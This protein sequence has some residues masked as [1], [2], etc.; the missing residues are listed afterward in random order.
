M[1]DGSELGDLALKEKPHKSQHFD[2]KAF[3]DASGSIL[4]QH[5]VGVCGI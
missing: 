5:R 3:E 4:S 1:L 2:G